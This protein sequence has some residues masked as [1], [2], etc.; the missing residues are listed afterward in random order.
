MAERT[1]SLILLLTALRKM[2]EELLAF[3]KRHSQYQGTLRYSHGILPNIQDAV[4]TRWEFN[5]SKSLWQTA[6]SLR[7]SNPPLDKHL[8]M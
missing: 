5:A 7:I 8:L 3:S 2:G 6:M 1:I 4:T